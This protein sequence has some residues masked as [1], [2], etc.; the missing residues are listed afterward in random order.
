MAV[1]YQTNNFEDWYK[2]QFKQ[3]FDP[4]KGLTRSDDMSNADWEYGNNLFSAYTQKNDATNQYNSYMQNLNQSRSKS[5]QEASIQHD[6]LMKYMPVQLKSQ[7]LG[8]LGLSESAMLQAGNMYQNTMGGINRDYSKS[9]MD[10]MDLYRTQ[11]SNIDQNLTRDNQ[12]LFD[13][14]LGYERE[15]QRDFYEDAL[16]RIRDLESFKTVE[17]LDNYFNAVKGKINPEQASALERELMFTRKKLE[18]NAKEAED[19]EVLAGKKLLS[20]KNSKYKLTGEEMSPPDEHIQFLLA[21]GFNGAYDKGI[22]NG[23]TVAFP[24]R[25]EYWTYFNNAWYKSKKV[26]SDGSSPARNP[27]ISK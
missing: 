8:G 22:P 14:Y 24:R 15:D 13:K 23:Y 5:Q 19:E 1:T 6:K 16:L 11:M 27:I 12:S 25:R 20:F 10:L 9:S 2:N 18:S 7:G 21:Q 17:D 4:N 26:F 3:N